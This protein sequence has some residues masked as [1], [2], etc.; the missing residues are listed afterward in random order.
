MMA[1]GELRFAA[2]AQDVKFDAGSAAWEWTVSEARLVGDTWLE[3]QVQEAD[4]D[5]KSKTS[6]LELS[7]LKAL[8]KGPN[9]TVSVGDEVKVPFWDK[10]SHD[11]LFGGLDDF[12]KAGNYATL[13]LSIYGGQGASDI[14][15]S[16]P[17]SAL[18]LISQCAPH[19]PQV[20]AEEIKQQ[21]E[22]AVLRRKRKAEKEQKDVLKKA[23]AVKDKEAAEKRRLERE[24]EL[25]AERK[26]EEQAAAEFARKGWRSYDATGATCPC[27][28]KLART[29]TFDGWSFREANRETD[30]TDASIIFR[31]PNEQEIVVEEVFPA[32]H[33]LLAGMLKRLWSW[34]LSPRQERQVFRRRLKDHRLIWRR[35]VWH[36]R[37][38][39]REPRE[40]KWV[41]FRS[42]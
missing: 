40:P 34:D 29:G 5:W 6:Y 16:A 22:A 20:T 27:L 17:V 39:T 42:G 32:A 15:Y 26:A 41:A 21:S 3:V 9:L 4:C 10:G 18:E 28:L 14:A 19:Q 24:K 2:E 23:Q 38:S 7:K 11:S 13:R 33:E 35:C 31:A 30:P 25:E 37:H 1:S 8:G 36:T 12:V